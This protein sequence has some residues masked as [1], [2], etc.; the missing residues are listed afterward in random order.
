MNKGQLIEAVASELGT[1]RTQAA[2]AV[3]AVL[4]SI[5]GGVRDSDGVTITGF[6]TFQKKSRAGRTVR[7]PATGAPM[8]LEPSMTV[9]FRPSQAL[10]DALAETAALPRG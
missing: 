8:V 6:G 4:R 3:D 5:Q 7:N 2:K 1:S 9:G 10:K